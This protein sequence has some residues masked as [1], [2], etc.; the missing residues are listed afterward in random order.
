MDKGVH[1]DMLTS[2]STRGCIPSGP[3]DF[4]IFNLSSFFLTFFIKEKVK[5]KLDKLKISKSPGPDGIHPRV[6]KEVSMSLCTPL[7]IIFETS[8]KTGLLPE[9]W[10]CANITAIYKKGHK[11]VAGNYRPISLTSFVCKLMETL[12]REEIIEHM[13][14]NKLFS[15]TQF[16]FISGRSTVLQQLQVLDKWTEILDK[17]GC[18][19]TIYCDFMKAFDKVPHLRLIHKLEKYQITGQTNNI[20]PSTDPCGIPLVTSL[21]SDFSPFTITL[22]FLPSKNDLIHPLNC[23]VI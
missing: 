14:R 21:H 12:V 11:K 22:C 19:D 2:F 8:N 23:P 20:G 7:S 3:G 10:K 18:V 1:S 5:K 17:G 6:L 9:D 16:G 13:K 4:E 15:K